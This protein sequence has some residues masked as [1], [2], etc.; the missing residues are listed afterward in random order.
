VVSWISLAA[1]HVA[2][3]SLIETIDFG[4]YVPDNGA[5]YPTRLSDPE[6]LTSFGEDE[7]GNLY[8]ADRNDGKVYR[9]LIRDLLFS[10]SF[11]DKS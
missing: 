3:M 6:R 7:Q 8:I 4:G 1:R 10:S 11:E 5:V 9:I 2:A